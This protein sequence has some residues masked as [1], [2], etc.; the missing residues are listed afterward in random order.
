[1]PSKFLHFENSVLH[2]TTLGNGPRK[3]LLFHGFGQ[4]S[5]SFYPLSKILSQEYTAYIFDL[6]FHGQS[7]WGHGE[8]P[9]EKK[10]WKETMDTFLT[11]NQIDK[12]SVAAYSLGGKFAL[13]TL[14]V[15]PAKVMGMILL[16]PDGIKTSFWYSLATYPVLFRRIFKHMVQHPEIFHA[17]IKMLYSWKLVDKGLLKFAKF[18]MNSPEKRI[19]VYYSWVVF[20]HLRFNINKIAG[21]I[22]E[23]KIPLT[24]AVGQYDKVIQPKNMER[25][26][27]KLNNYTFE[28]PEVGHTGLIAASGQYFHNLK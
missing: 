5:N 23:Y 10:H 16:A 20:R 7:K 25:L 6:Y 17:I 14:E 19:R 2:Y 21:L 12:F 11:E 18:Q 24:L 15:F 1:M 22:N 9:I 3:L 4:D 13:A 26:I 8:A 28:T 27:K